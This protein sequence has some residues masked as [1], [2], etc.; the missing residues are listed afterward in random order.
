[1]LDVLRFVVRLAADVVRRRAGLVAENALLRPKLIVA[2]RKIAG[3]GRW[4]PWLRFTMGSPHA[5]RRR[6]ATPRCSSSRRPSSAG[7]GQAYSGDAGSSTRRSHPRQATSGARRTTVPRYPALPKR[8]ASPRVGRRDSPARSW[9]GRTSYGRLR[10]AGLLGTSL[11]TPS[12]Y[13]PAYRVPGFV[14]SSTA[15]AVI[16]NRPGKPRPTGCHRRDAPR[17]SQTPAMSSCPKKEKP[18][19]TYVVDGRVEVSKAKGKKNTGSP[20]TVL[21]RPV[22]ALRQRPWAALWRI[23]M[24]ESPRSTR[25]RCAS[26]AIPDMD[27][28]C[29]WCG[30]ASRIP[31]I[32]HVVPSAEPETRPGSVTAWIVGGWVEGSTTMSCTRASMPWR[33]CQL[34]PASREP[35]MPRNVARNTPAGWVVVSSAT[36]TAPDEGRARLQAGEDV[37]RVK[38]SPLP[39]SP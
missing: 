15:R 13:V 17:L 22:P 38:M 34:T 36:A 27:A 8:S 19:P 6:G 24:P 18:D 9:V 32:R 4:A 31:S 30:R 33:G 29:S 23:P 35:R 11:R 16:S 3:R 39:P 5:W 10:C 28:A 25:R 14:E 2:Q 7:T 37:V 21:G 1:M 12:P 20:P 26:K